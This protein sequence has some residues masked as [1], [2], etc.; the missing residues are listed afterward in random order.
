MDLKLISYWIIS[1]GLQ[2]KNENL[3]PIGNCDIEEYRTIDDA[4]S[5]INSIK[6]T[7]KDRKGIDTSV[8]DGVLDVDVEA[9]TIL[10]VTYNESMKIFN[11]KEVKEFYYKGVE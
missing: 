6:A 5:F 10:E 7:P 3:A 9:I 4:L 1:Q 8:I 2:A 11:A